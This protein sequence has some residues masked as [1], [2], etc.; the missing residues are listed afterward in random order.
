M[1]LRDSYV[2]LVRSPGAPGGQVLAKVAA[3]RD[4][5]DGDVAV[6]VAG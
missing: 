1:L 5:G 6:G 2:A 3:G 4:V